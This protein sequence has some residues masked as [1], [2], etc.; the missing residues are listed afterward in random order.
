MNSAEDVGLAGG[1]RILVRTFPRTRG[2]TA[3]ESRQEGRARPV[4]SRPNWYPNYPEI[5]MTT[6]RELLAAFAGTMLAYSVIGE[7][8]TIEQR[9]SV[10]TLGVKGLAMYRD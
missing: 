9:I 2:T 10:V 8:Q 7:G 3:T 6:R 1:A 5:A 4:Y